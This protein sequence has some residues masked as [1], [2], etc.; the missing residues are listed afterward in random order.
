MKSVDAFN[1]YF[2]GIGRALAIALAGAGAETFALSKTIENLQSLS[3]VV[4][5]RVSYIAGMFL[6][7]ILNFYWLVKYYNAF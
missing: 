4:C 6:Y 1:I 2:P 7:C 5:F 3:K